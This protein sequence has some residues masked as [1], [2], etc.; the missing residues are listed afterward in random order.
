LPRPPTYA[1]PPS[2]ILVRFSEECPESIVATTI[3]RLNGH[4]GLGLVATDVAGEH[5]NAERQR[6][7]GLS[8]TDAALRRE[9]EQIHL[10]KAIVDPTQI[11]GL[12]S[13][14]ENFVVAAG[15]MVDFIDA[16][17][18]PLEF[19]TTAEIH[20]LVHS[21]FDSVRLLDEKNDDRRSSTRGD[22]YLTKKNTVKSSALSEA[23][24]SYQK[25]KSSGSTFTA[26]GMDYVDSPYLHEQMKKL[27]LID[28]VTP[29]HLARER[30]GVMQLMLKPSPWRTGGIDES[31]MPIYRYY[32]SQCAYYFAWMD[33]YTRCLMF[34]GAAGLGVYAYRT[35]VLQ[36]SVD[37]C[38][39]TP[40]FGLLMFLWGVFFLRYWERYE[41]RYAWMWGTYATSETFIEIETRANFKGTPRIS[42]V[43]GAVQMHYP[44]WRRRLKQVVSG[45]ITSCLLCVA[46]FW[47][48]CSLNLQGYVNPA[49]DRN[50]WPE[51]DDHIFHIPYLAD[52]A[53]PGELLD[54]NTHYGLIPVVIHAL[55]IA[56]FNM[57]YRSIAIHLTEWENHETDEHFE[58]SLIL[59][60]FCFEA[61]DAFLPLLY[62][63]FYEFDV[64]KLRGELV[65]L[66][67]VDMLRR[68]TLECLVPMLLHT[69][70]RRGEEK[71]TKNEVGL[72][73]KFDDLDGVAQYNKDGRSVLLTADD[74]LDQ[75]ELDEYEIF[76]DYLEMVI[77]LGYI[78]IFASVYPLAAA[79]ASLSC[80]VEIRTDAIKISHVTRKPVPARV[81]SIGIWNQLISVIIWFSCLTNC[82]I[83]CFSTDQL[84]QWMPSMELNRDDWDSVANSARG[85]HVVRF[86]FVLEHAI[87]L[88]GILLYSAIP[89]TPA[90]VAA[91]I[92]HRAYVRSQVARQRRK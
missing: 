10:Q 81:A 73:K 82:L 33:C 51:D 27:N 26:D 36:V 92:K 46:F 38:P 67:N 61:F 12:T 57:T 42:P 59:K 44:A 31:I 84:A 45:L 90:D 3:D 52:L 25:T 29:L 60:R 70:R 91:G 53:Q 21:L 22:I 72:S 41:K 34:P 76:D 47:I 37:D 50:R 2:C 71:K 54:C 8:A 35:T 85:E 18:S 56:V 88:L 65:S 14:R 49:H 86:M 15:G 1:P 9:A 77:Q 62:L 43:T 48:I 19:F 6:C 63:A 83:V 66:F 58:N 89:S 5:G 79:L 7:I 20:L 11:G 64:A 40:F 75:A 87:L 23:I 30:D 32:G 16:E 24:D 4:M 55:V 80:F 28:V 17:A 74:V 69:I 39:Y 68:L 13:I 78:C